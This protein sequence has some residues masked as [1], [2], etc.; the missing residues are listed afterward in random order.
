MKMLNFTLETVFIFYTAVTSRS[1]CSLVFCIKVVL[2]LYLV[3]SK[4]TGNRERI[5]MN[6]IPNSLKENLCTGDFL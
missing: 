1:R 6:K 4:D 3:H 2:G 5:P